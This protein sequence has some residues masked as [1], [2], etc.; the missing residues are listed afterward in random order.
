MSRQPPS[1]DI[2]IWG[3]LVESHKMFAM[4]SREFLAAG[5]DRVRLLRDALRG[6][7]RSTAIY[8]LSYLT[9]AELEQ[10]FSDLVFLVS[11]SHGAVGAVRNAILSLP[12]EWVLANI[13]QVADPLLGAGT[14]DEYRR[15]L[16]LYIELDYELAYELAQRAAGH[17]DQDIRE[18]GEDF[19]DKLKGNSDLVS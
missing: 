10:L 19:L 16:E 7:D 11:F 2:V 8:M 4:A 12:R 6:K 5:V 13:N 14:Y 9:I 1:N 18:A 17:T 15:F 3:R